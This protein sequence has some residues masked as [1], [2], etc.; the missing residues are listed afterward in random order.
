MFFEHE[1]E[2]KV[3]NKI[4]RVSE[5]I[6]HSGDPKSLLFIGR[7]APTPTPTSSPGTMVRMLS[8]VSSPFQDPE[9]FIKQHSSHHGF[10]TCLLLAQNEV[11]L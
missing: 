1:M 9:A 2:Y 6:G 8:S 3:G 11:K 5:I 10:L 4:R 7:A